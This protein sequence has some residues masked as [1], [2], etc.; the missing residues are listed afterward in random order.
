MKKWQIAVLV[1]EQSIINQ[2]FNSPITHLNGQDLVSDELVCEILLELNIYFYIVD[3]TGRKIL[4]LMP[5]DVY[6]LQDFKYKILEK[7]I[8]ILTAYKKYGEI[9]TEVFDYG[10]VDVE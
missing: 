9:I 8:H 6:F 3:I 5:I 1:E 4:R 10:S 2:Y 7:D